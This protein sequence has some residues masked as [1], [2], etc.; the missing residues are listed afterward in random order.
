MPGGL[1]QIMAM[2]AQDHYLINDPQ[3]TFFRLTYR[4]QTNFAVETSTIKPTIIKEPKIKI[5]QFYLSEGFIKNIKTILRRQRYILTYKTINTPIL[6]N[7]ECPITLN[8]ITDLYLE[9]S[10][11]KMCYDYNT[12][13]HYF[14]N[15]SKCSYC[16]QNINIKPLGLTNSSQIYLML[17]N[18]K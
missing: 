6:K 12:T 15:T 18:S 4:R 1:L 13:I 3:I 16:R 7:T 9:C 10:T 8:E 2:G 14:K 5:R 11:C 17:K